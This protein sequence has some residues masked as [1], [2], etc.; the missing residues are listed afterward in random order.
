MSSVAEKRPE[1]GHSA[2]AVITRNQVTLSAIADAVLRK[3][4][5]T[6][7]NRGMAN[8]PVLIAKDGAEQPIV[9]DAARC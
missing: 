6:D 9:D 1:S 7:L 4:Q 2:A 3:V 8:H 5:E